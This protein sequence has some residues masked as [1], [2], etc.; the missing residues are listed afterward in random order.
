MRH[1]GGHEDNRDGGQAKQR[2]WEWDMKQRLDRKYRSCC[3]TTPTYPELGATREDLLPVGYDHLYRRVR[4][5][6]GDETFELYRTA[7]RTW[8]PQRAAGI[9]VYP[10]DAAP[11][12]GATVLLW[13]SFGPC[14]L[15][16]PCRIVWTVDDPD[17][18]GFG[19][20]TLPGHPE[21]GEESFTVEQD[22][23]GD[24][25]FVVRA[26]SRPATWFARLGAPITRLIQ[27]RITD[28]YAQAWRPRDQS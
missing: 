26:F 3:S 22:T 12:I 5:G 27:K 18:T 28:A 11:L 10:S 16:A 4:L 21:Q 2:R 19:Y 8:A 6:G 25:W 13:W 23:A 24:V 7:L 1:P 9:T 14:H 15:T 20:G 17:R